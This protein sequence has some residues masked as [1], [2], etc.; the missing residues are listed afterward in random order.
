[1]KRYPYRSNFFFDDAKTI[2]DAVDVPVALLGGV[3]S[4]AAVEQA[5]G[6]GFEFVAL[7]R[8]LLADPDFIPRLAAGESV[9]SR[10]THCNICVAEMDRDGVRCVLDPV[11]SLE[12]LPLEA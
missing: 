12:S 10:C 1:M 8:A 3:D 2:L 11:P 7:G 5:M 6:S 9:V 4:A